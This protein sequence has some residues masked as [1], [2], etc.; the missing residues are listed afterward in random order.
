MDLWIFGR[1]FF[2]LSLD[3]EESDELELEE[4]ELD[5]EE[6]GFL[7]FFL[8]G[9][10]FDLDFSFEGGGEGEGDFLL[11]RDSLDIF[12]GLKAGTSDLH[13]DLLLSTCSDESSSPSSF[14]SVDLLFLILADTASVFVITSSISI[15]SRGSSIICSGGLFSGAEGNISCLSLREAFVSDPIVGPLTWG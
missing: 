11:R 6:L 12:L 1:F 15:S 4:D 2:A 3:L 5:E 14:S 8:L 9:T 7:F 13:R 10:D